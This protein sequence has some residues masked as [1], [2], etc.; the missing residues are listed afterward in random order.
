MEIK[1]GSRDIKTKNE[2]TGDK[3]SNISGAFRAYSY[4][5]NSINQLGSIARINNTSKSAED[6]LFSKAM[7]AVRRALFSKRKK[8]IYA[9]AALLALFLLILFS[10]LAYIASTPYGVFLSEGQSSGEGRYT[11]REAVRI[12]NYEYNAE[13]DTLLEKYSVDETIKSGSCA[14]WRE[15]LA[16]FSVLRSK[17]NQST[18]LLNRDGLDRLREVFRLINFYEVAEYEEGEIKAELIL[19]HISAFDAG[20]AYSFSD[21]EML[22]LEEMLGDDMKSA[23]SAVLYGSGED[24]AVIALNELGNAGGQT[25][26]S[27]YGFE[28]RVEWCACFVSWCADQAGL[29]DEKLVPKFDNCASGAAWFK[30][31]DMFEHPPYTPNEGDIV[32]FDWEGDGISD[33]VG[34]VTSSEN[35]II[36][37]V[38]GNSADMVRQGSYNADDKC[39]FGYGVYA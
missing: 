21:S 24:I 19:G 29:I 18:V 2:G 14:P 1:Y 38:E 5:R 11:M 15:V 3:K 13:I 28:S 27:W 25:Y 39:I 34:I 20:R 30:S 23:W 26:W 7:K 10:T 16:V 31:H 35:G 33:H 9:L 4:A 8:W 36:S 22:L 32:F 37:T 6:E 12:I 17:D